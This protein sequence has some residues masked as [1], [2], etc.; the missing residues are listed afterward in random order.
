[1]ATF[2]FTATLKIYYLYYCNK[3][4]A[5]IIFQRSLVPKCIRCGI[6]LPRWGKFLFPKSKSANHDQRFKFLKRSRWVTELQTSS[7]ISK[8]L[9]Y[10]IILPHHVLILNYLSRQES[11]QTYDTVIRVKEYALNAGRYLL[12]Q[13]NYKA[14]RISKFSQSLSNESLSYYRQSDSEQQG[15]THTRICDIF[16]SHTVLCYFNTHHRF[17][18]KKVPQ[19]CK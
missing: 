17:A 5:C 16:N 11:S 9:V 4:N 10:Q 7:S 6:I 13:W 19:L 12:F 1:M 15:I 2:A 8:R 18:I 3:R 14:N